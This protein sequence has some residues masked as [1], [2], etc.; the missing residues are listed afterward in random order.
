MSSS[1][2]SMTMASFK[3]ATTSVILIIKFSVKGVPVVAQGMQV[4]SLGFLA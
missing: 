1:S 4:Q 2:D 3:Y